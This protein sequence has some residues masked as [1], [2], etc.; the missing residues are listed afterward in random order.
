MNPISFRRRRFFYAC[1][2]TLGLAACGGGGGDDGDTGGDQSPDDSV[3]TGSGSVTVSGK[4]EY[5]FVPAVET[6]LDFN[7]SA[8]KPVRQAEVEATCGTGTYASAVTDE[9]GAYSLTV[10]E[11][12]DVVIRARAAMSKS[13]SPGW[14]VNVVDNTQSQ[15]TWVLQGEQFNSGTGEV[16]LN[17]RAESGWT[18]S[19]GSGARG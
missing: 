7:N 2:A 10:P 11:N 16:T 19:S 5:E 14:T 4:V 9:Q 18:G 12:V 1:L 3:C 17:L 6:G 15:A 13:G 8:F